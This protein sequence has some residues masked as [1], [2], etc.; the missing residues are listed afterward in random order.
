MVDRGA[1][2]GV[3]G[4]D[5]LVEQRGISARPLD[6]RNSK[7]ASEVPVAVR[8]SRFSAVGP[9]HHIAVDGRAD[10]HPLAARR[11]HRQ[12]DAR[13]HRPGQ[14]VE[15]QQL[16]APRRD[17][18]AVMAERGS[19]WSAPR[20]AALT[21][22]RAVHVAAGGL[23]RRAVGLAGHRTG[24][25][26]AA[27]AARAA[28]HGIGGQGEVGGPGA[29]DR[30]AG[31]RQPAQYAGAEVAGPADTPRRHRRSRSGG[32]SFV[33]PCPSDREARRALRRSTR[34]AV[35][36][37][38]RPGY[39]SVR[40]SRRATRSRAPPVA[41]RAYRASRRIRCAAARCWPCWCRH[42]RRRV[43]RAGSTERFVPA[44]ARAI[45][46]PTIPPPTTM[47]ST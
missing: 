42:R 25:P 21:T 38:A 3:G 8:S 35:R 44:S 39:P 10:Q 11:R 30:L 4:G 13:H 34:P 45:A 22:Q 18:E 7:P 36:R 41:T 26:R 20:P 31:H 28:R 15:H 46:E 6:S 5:L 33:R 1:Q 17:G 16:A 29:D 12:H 43:P 23:Q 24:Y 14:L 27:H 37:C 19:R 40:R 2:P 9:D 32:R 47:T